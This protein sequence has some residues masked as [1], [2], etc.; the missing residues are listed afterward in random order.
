MGTKNIKELEDLAGNGDVGAIYELG[1]RYFEGIGVEQ[2]VQKAREYFEIAA[3]RGSNGS[4]YFLGKIY[5]NGMGVQT[6]HVKAK[7]YFEKSA[8][9]KNA[10]SEYYLGKIYFWG[11]GVEKNYN[12]ANEYKQSVLNRPL[13]SNQDTGIEEFYSIADFEAQTR[14]YVGELQNK[15]ILEYKKLFGND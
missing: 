7:E 2:N 6:N 12:K 15:V 3:E 14:Q 10:F 9:E 8:A 1:Q 4:N 13:Y 5:Y 11:D